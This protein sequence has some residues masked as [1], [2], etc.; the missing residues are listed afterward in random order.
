MMIAR[1]MGEEMLIFAQT[2]AQ[3]NRAPCRWPA[4]KAALS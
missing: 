1:L 4:T 3:D 2:A